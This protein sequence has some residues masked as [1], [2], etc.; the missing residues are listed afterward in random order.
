MG[1]ETLLQRNDALAEYGKT[2]V[3]PEH[4][5]ILEI[6]PFYGTMQCM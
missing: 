3:F 5:G 2:E 6:T 4:M 1:H